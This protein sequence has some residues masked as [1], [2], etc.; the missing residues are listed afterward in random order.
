MTML[1]NDNSVTLRDRDTM[2]QV[3]VGIDE[4]VSQSAEEDELLDDHFLMLSRLSRTWNLRSY[5]LFLPL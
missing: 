2:E 5:F 4:H 3:R 1:S